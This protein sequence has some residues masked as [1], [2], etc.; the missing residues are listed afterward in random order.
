[1]VSA[2]VVE[3]AEL[4]VVV[5]LASSVLVAVLLLSFM[6]GTATSDDLIRPDTILPR[7][8]PAFDAART[9]YLVRS[10]PFIHPHR[11]VATE[12]YLDFHVERESV[13]TVPLLLPMT[14][15]FP[16]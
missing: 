12:P 9:P 13:A 5:T 4:L 14:L 16:T 8:S 7:E 10:T 1:M 6:S 2:V 11:G 15:L 3:D